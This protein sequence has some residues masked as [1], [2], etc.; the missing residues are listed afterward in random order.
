MEE[1][2]NLMVDPE[3]LLYG[4]IVLLIGLYLGILVGEMGA[5]KREKIARANRAADLAYA[6]E[7]A[8]D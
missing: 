4:A 3:M 2:V 8:A 6:Q 1:R 5:T 7:M